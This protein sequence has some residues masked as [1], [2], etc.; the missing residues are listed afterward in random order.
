[1]AKIRIECD[2]RFLKPMSDIESALRK[3][4][5]LDAREITLQA[6]GPNPVVIELEDLAQAEQLASSLNEILDV[7]ASIE[8]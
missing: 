6:C 3:H 4:G 8:P 2:Q 5:R 1:M 7:Q